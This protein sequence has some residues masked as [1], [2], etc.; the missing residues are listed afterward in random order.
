MSDLL[1][2][3]QDALFKALKEIEGADGLPEFTVYQHVPEDGP[4]DPFRNKIV[5]GQLASENAEG[6]I[7]PGEA[8]E[9]ISAEIGFVFRGT[10]RGPMLAMMRAARGVLQNGGLEAQGAEFEAPRWVSAEASNALADGVTYVG[11]QL[12]RFHAAPA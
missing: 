3:A 9:E 4:G 6:K 7:G 10:G 11:I 12:Y 2:P 8:L 1:E 5:V